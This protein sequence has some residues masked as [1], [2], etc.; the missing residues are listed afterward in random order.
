LELELKEKVMSLPKQVQ[1]QMAELEVLER[2]IAEQAGAPVAQQEGEPSEQ[3]AIEATPIAEAEVFTADKTP[4]PTEVPVVKDAKHDDDELTWKQ[5]YQT[6]LGMYNAEVP[7][8]HTRIKDSAATIQTLQEEVARFKARPVEAP[9]AVEIK[10]S[11][12]T[13]KDKEE[14]GEDL[15][16]LQRRIA[17]EMVEPLSSKVVSL[18]SEN[19]TL[20]EQL[21]KTGAQIDTFTF[22]QALSVAIPDFKSVNADPRWV[23]WLDEV[24]PMIR[25]PRRSV[26]QA[27]FNSGDVAG[28]QQ[29]IE[30]WRNSLGTVAPKV[31]NQAELRA[32]VTPNRNAATTQTAPQGDRSYTEAEADKVWAKI[33]TLG[34]QGKTEEANKLESELSTAYAT[35]RVR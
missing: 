12:V 1:Q 27:A 23:A 26:A 19:A 3:T 22:E 32:Q 33:V 29:Y 9:K 30:L 31:D 16:D 18:E 4:E 8:M 20:R 28:I 21:G 7:G 2:S 24:D 25:G 6:L 34:K 17:T 5:R 11:S 15:I 10:A 13:D 35:G 14:F